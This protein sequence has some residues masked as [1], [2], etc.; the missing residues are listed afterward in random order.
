MA[1]AAHRRFHKLRR[2]R[3]FTL[4]E[5]LIVVVIAG[6]TLGAV[7]FSA[8]NNDRQALQNDARRIAMLLQLTRDEAIL[9]NRPTAFEADATGYRFLVSAPDGWQGLDQNT[10][11]RPRKFVR[12]PL[13]LSLSPARV[14]AGTPDLLR[15]PFGREPIDKPFVLTLDAGDATVAVHADGLGHFWTE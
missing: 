11:M 5:L 8:F 14:D 6:I 1:L 7:S 2:A 3:G 9:R 15:I 13:R 12:F 10:L 4:L